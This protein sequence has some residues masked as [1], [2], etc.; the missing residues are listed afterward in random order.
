MC[1]KILQPVKEC[2]S[3]I[4]DILREL[5]VLTKMNWNSANF[6]GLFP[7]TLRFSS[8]VG[9]IMKEFPRDVDP[10]PQFKYYM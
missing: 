9:E 8:L 3:S 10:L 1:L 7:I 4:K 2:Y 5:M 6:G